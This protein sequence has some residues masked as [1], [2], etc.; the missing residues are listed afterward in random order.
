MTKAWRWSSRAGVTSGTNRVLENSTS[1]ET[2]PLAVVSCGPA[3]EPI[4]GVRRLTN[5]ATGEIGSILSAALQ[6]RGYDVICFRGEGSTAAAPTGVEMQSFSTNDSLAQAFQ[7]LSRQPNLILHAAALCDFKV[8][9]VEGADLREK[10]SSRK[11]GITI[12]L[13]PAPKILPQLREWFPQALIV[14]WKYELDGQRADAIE[15]GARQLRET[16]SDVCVLNGKA[17][18]EGFG[19]LFRDLSL[20]HCSDKKTLAQALIEIFDKK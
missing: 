19:I 10:I 6:E 13:Q 15:S 2:S 20:R 8:A 16:G 7:A 12:H 1:L 17:Y 3:F 18:G 9:S 5:F 14:G 4:D 11:G